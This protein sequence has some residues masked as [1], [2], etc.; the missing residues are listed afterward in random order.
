MSD[1]PE[2]FPPE[3]WFAAFADG[4]KQHVAFRDINGGTELLEAEWIEENVFLIR[5]LPLL[6]DGVGP[7]SSVEVFWE[8]GDVTPRF[9]RAAGEPD[10]RVVRVPAY[11]CDVE[12]LTALDD[13]LD[14]DY[15]FRLF[16]GRCRRGRGVFVFCLED[17]TL[18]QL[19]EHGL[20]LEMLL[21]RGWRFTDGGGQV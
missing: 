8:E 10:C 11:D 18:A 16:R 2:K 15:F 13:E 14:R 20:S 21:P 6:V 9:L 19:R 4:R 5:E 1:A 7:Y 12:Q 3:E 17:H